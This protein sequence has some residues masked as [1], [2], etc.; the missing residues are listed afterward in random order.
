M[1]NYTKIFITILLGL[2]FTIPLFSQTKQN[3]TIEKNMQVSKHIKITINGKIAKGIL[4]D[5]A[6]AKTFETLLPMSVKLEDFNNTEKIVKLKRALPTQGA[7][8]G[9]EPKTGDLS[10]YEP[11]G[12][13]AIFYKDFRYSESLVSFGKVTEGLAMLSVKG[14]VDVTIELDETKK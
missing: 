10:Y 5:N 13:I 12:N 7:P 4:Y 9:Y 11:W 14:D 2:F 1:K 6:T 3:K 8:S